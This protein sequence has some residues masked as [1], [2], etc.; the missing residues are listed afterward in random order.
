MNPNISTT[1]LNS[2]EVLNELIFQSLD[3]IL[4]TPHRIISRDLPFS[5]GQPILALDNKQRPALI[6]SDYLDGGQA[7]LAGLKLLESLDAHRTWIFR[8]YPELL[9]ND[10]QALRVEDIQL[11]IVA[12]TPP[13]GRVY[14]ERLLTQIHS[15]TFQPLLING[16]LGLLLDPA[17][18]TTAAVENKTSRADIFRTGMPELEKTEEDYFRSLNI[19]A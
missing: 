15:V 14:L 6:V 2:N 4:G 7:L 8:L 16:D 1:S 9:G 17:N 19:S 5:S 13:P 18:A 11:Y 12:P 10:Q 3:K